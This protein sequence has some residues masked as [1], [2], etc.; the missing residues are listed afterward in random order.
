M[1]RKKSGICAHSDDAVYEMGLLGLGGGGHLEG[2]TY[3]AGRCGT[4]NSILQY[5]KKI[6]CK[7]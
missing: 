1:Q 6:V 3:K 4:Q 5:F 2:F 7:I